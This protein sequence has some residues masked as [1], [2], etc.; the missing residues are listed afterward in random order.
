MASWAQ[1]GLPGPGGHRGSVPSPEQAPWHDVVNSGTGGLGQV[2]GLTRCVRARVHVCMYVRGYL[3][4]QEGTRT[5]V[6][7]VFAN[8]HGWET[9]P[10]LAARQGG[11]MAF[12]L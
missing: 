8:G 12:L 2:P 9:Q 6:F 1:W 3:G 7:G 4:R 5:G 10:R 11:V